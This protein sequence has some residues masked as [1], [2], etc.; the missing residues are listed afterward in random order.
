MLIKAK[1]SIGTGYQYTLGTANDLSVG[2]NILVWSL[3]TAAIIGSGNGQSV[4]VSGTVLGE[5]TGIQ[6]TGNNVKI[7]V[8][9]NASVMGGVALS[10]ANSNL[11]IVNRGVIAGEDTAIRTAPESAL[12]NSI[13]RVTNYGLI[14]GVMSGL[15]FAYGA[16]AVVRNFG[17]IESEGTVFQGGVGKDV[18]INRGIIKGNN[19]AL[20]FGHDIY[21]GRGGKVVG[22]S[23]FGGPGNDTFRPGVSGEIMNGDQGLDTLDFRAGPGIKVDLTNTFANTGFAKGDTYIDMNRVLGSDRGADV[24]R[25]NGLG[26]ELRGNGGNDRLI[27]ALGN[28]S[29]IGGAGRDT[30]T[31]GDGD[32]S[33]IFLKPSEGGDKITDFSS[34]GG[35]FDVIVIDASGFGGGLSAGVLPTGR[36]K[37]GGNNQA[38]D[39]NDRFI[40]R[41]TDATL[42]FDRDGQGGAGPV[43]IA[44]LQA[45]ASLSAGAFLLI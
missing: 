16:G 36:L 12:P 9:E 8:H 21:D 11:A 23:I 19:I 13:A 1:N 34:V 10:L 43:L 26:N 3:D 37:I 45:G 33:F 6:L 28:D 14:E 22:A 32:E 24:L 20:S 4:V 40:F 39:A 31:G 15:G 42:W 29:L 18:L 30:L 17:V 44:D 27:G 2:R 5:A 35:N 38:G 25:A 41:T 7:N